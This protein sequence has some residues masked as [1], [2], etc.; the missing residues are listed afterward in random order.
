[1][2]LLIS[3]IHQ[4]SVPRI[5]GWTILFPHHTNAREIQLERIR[6]CEPNPSIPRKSF[7]KC[8][9]RRRV[10]LI[11]QHGFSQLRHH[12]TIAQLYSRDLVLYRRI[13]ERDTLL[14]CAIHQIRSRRVHLHI[15]VHQH[16]VYSPAPAE[17]IP[18][19]IKRV[20]R[21]VQRLVRCTGIV[22]PRRPC[23]TESRR[24][25]RN[26][27]IHQQRHPHVGHHTLGAQLY[28]RLLILSRCIVKRYTPLN[29]PACKIDRCGSHTNIRIGKL[30]I[31]R[32]APAR[33]YLSILIERLDGDRNRLVGKAGKAEALRPG[34]AEGGQ[35][36][37]RFP[38]IH[39]PSAAREAV[40]YECYDK[41]NGNTRYCS[42]ESSYFIPVIHGGSPLTLDYSA[43]VGKGAFTQ[44]E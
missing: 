34:Q 7:K 11:D 21:H 8:Y 41:G 19:R 30:Y 42:T 3:F 20:D 33:E 24:L 39:S 4:L 26:T 27:R 25:H 37:V 14:H 18:A 40:K 13:T 35:Y 10:R 17:H 43:C 36:P 32:P 22:K 16:Y 6:P 23:K 2:I 9:I 1:M 44:C 12:I 28:P 15:R 5:G 38:Y 31:N 29:Y